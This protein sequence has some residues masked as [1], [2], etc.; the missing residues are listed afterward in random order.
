[1]RVCGASQ[2]L[3][4]DA[5]RADGPGTELCEAAVDGATVLIAGPAVLLLTQ[6]E[7]A[8]F[9]EIGVGIVEVS[10]KEQKPVTGTEIIFWT[11]F[12]YY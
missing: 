8:A 12:A 4:L 9:P 2:C 10:V 1:M 11:L 5:G 3:F 7:A 6:L